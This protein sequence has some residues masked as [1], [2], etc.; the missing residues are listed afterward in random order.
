MSKK[1]SGVRG[2]KQL[3][4]PNEIHG[5]TLT[6]VEEFAKCASDPVYFVKTYMKIRTADGQVIPFTLWPWQEDLLRLYHEN[7]FVIS[8]IARQSGKTSVS[9]AY[10][11]WLALFHEQKLIAI[12]AN[13]A[14][15][16]RSIL[17]RIR[18]AY[19]HL[20]K[21]LQQGV[22]TWNKGDIELGNGSK[23][24]AYSTSAESVRGETFS[25]ILLDELAF[26]EPNVAEEFY[27]STYPAITGGKDTK[28]FIV[29][30]PN[31]IGNLYHTMW[32]KA[33]TGKSNFKPFTVNWW[34]VPGR[35]E[36]WKQETIANTSERQFEQEFNIEF[37]GSAD[38]LISGQ[39]LRLLQG[40][41]PVVTN[42]DGLAIY[43]E[44]IEKHQYAITVDV[45]RGEG[46]DYSAFTVFDITTIP[47]KIVA[48]FRNNKIDPI[49]FPNHVFTVGNRYNEAF[50]LVELNDIGAQIADILH[51]DLEYENMYY[52]SPKDHLGALTVGSTNGRYNY[53]L[54]M[55]V[56]SKK[57]GCANLKA[58]VEDDKLTIPDWETIKELATFVRH[59][60]TYKAQ[61]GM[62]DDLAMT[63][64]MFG[65]LVAQ[66]EFRNTSE[67]DIFKHLS[68][69]EEEVPN[70]IVFVDENVYPILSAKSGKFAEKTSTEVWVTVDTEDNSWFR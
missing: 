13:K 37:L 33:E 35:D 1:N 53:G 40:I 28:I 65:W 48:R 20:P 69:T 27:T 46:Q 43:E 29:S 19:E 4:N 17:A 8:R 52:S 60:N 62:H 68:G 63:L 58:L 42:Q 18:L 25:A 49:V 26:V 2:N 22:I 32:V 30:T 24:F 34:D 23:I 3:V 56:S 6:E 70:P 59:N 51:Y 66:K 9:I 57:I 16:S 31:G 15:T 41:D 14:S 64:V 61:E 44:P 38:T 55:S 47:Y 21:F 50:V 54:K 10:F 7:R 11:L 67:T 36:K 39:K 45:A 12:L 5:Y